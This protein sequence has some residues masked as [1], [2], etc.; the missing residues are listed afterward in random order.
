MME[1]YREKEVKPFSSFGLLFIQL[2]IIFG[3][4]YVVL[5][6]GLPQIDPELLYSFIPRPDTPPSPLLLGLLDVTVKS[7]PLA[8]LAGI[9]QFWQ[10]SLALPKQ[11]KEAA[12]R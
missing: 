9:T 1:L 10:T 2:P 11:N 3:L 4:Y 6:S 5:K 8:L 12:Q 7:F